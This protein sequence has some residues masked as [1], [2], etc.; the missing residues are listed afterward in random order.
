MHFQQVAVD[1]WRFHTVRFASAPDGFDCY[2]WLE[3][4][5]AISLGVIL[6]RL[7]FPLHT[8]ELDPVVLDRA[9]NPIGLMPLLISHFLSG[10]MIGT[11][12]SRPN[13]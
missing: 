9:D 12:A 13:K 7:I 10:I 8:S 11:K 3:R 1:Q 6:P 2:C 4:G 5:L